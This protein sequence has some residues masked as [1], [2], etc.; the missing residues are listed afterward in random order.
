MLWESLS[1][2]LILTELRQAFIIS[3]ELSHTD[4]HWSILPST[5]T[6]FS[7]NMEAFLL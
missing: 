6:G 1:L 4:A 7:K 2:G 3:E 5:H